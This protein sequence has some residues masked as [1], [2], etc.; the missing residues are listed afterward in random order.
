[1]LFSIMALLLYIPTNNVQ[2]FHILNI[3]FFFLFLTPKCTCVCISE[4][5]HPHSGDLIISNSFPSNFH[6]TRILGTSIHAW[7]V[8]YQSYHVG[9]NPRSATQDPPSSAQHLP[10]LL[11]EILVLLLLL[12]A[13]LSGVRWHITVVQ[14][15]ISPM[16][17]SCT[18]WPFVCLLLRNVCKFIVCPFFKI[19]FCFVL[20]LSA[21]YIL[22]INSLLDVQFVNSFSHFISCFFTLLIVAF[23]VQKLFSLI[24][25]FIYICK[26]LPSPRSCSIS[27]CFL[28]VVSL[29]QNQDLSS[30]MSYLKICISFC[31]TIL[32]FGKCHFNSS[33]ATIKA[34]DPQSDIH[35]L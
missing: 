9:L 21:L 32:S 23:A 3:C 20:F 14:I 1:M 12:M 13:V 18:C 2:G 16:I 29:G 22:D 27:Q 10:A 6:S 26:I 5:K 17:F 11:Q 30:S 24:I 19:G 33:S 28:L 8:G 34:Y 31:F 4:R 35:N 15:C 25:P 7:H